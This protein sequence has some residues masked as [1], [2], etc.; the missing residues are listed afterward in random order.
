MLNF[1]GKKR[2]QNETIAS[3][4]SASES[5][6]DIPLTSVSEASSVTAATTAMIATTDATFQLPV[7]ESACQHLHAA[8]NA[9]VE[10]KVPD[11]IN[12]KKSLSGV[13]CMESVK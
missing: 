12:F 10:H 2:R 7:P 6:T 1:S 4:V 5:S 13:Q 3:V 11:I 8:R 9:F